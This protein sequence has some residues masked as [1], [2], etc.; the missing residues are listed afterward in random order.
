[1]KIGFIG[2]GIMGKP[3]SKNL[4]KAGHELV[5]CDFNKD[6]V[7]EVVA[8]GAKEGANGAEIAKECDVIITMLP[9]SPHVRS[10]ALG[11][12][13]IVE[14]AHEGTVLIDMSSID[15]VESKKIGAELAKKGIEMLDAPVSGGEPKAIDGT[16][17]VMVGGKKELF[18]KYYDMLMVM[19]GSVVY[20]GELGSGNVAKLANQIVVAVNIAAVGEALSFAK[21]AGTDPELV[22]QAIRGGLAGSTVMDAKAP[23]MLSRNFKPGFRIELH[24]KDLTN[25][26]NAAHAIAAPVPLTGQ[27]ME[28]MQ[29]LKADGYEKEDHSSLVKYYEKISNVT[30]E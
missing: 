10:V 17:S 6:A 11:E 26:L 30:V 29:A 8:A 23:M 16:L 9:N 22:Y 27:L 4:L 21:K 1:M 24:I 18:D 28:M 20:V 7:A 14:G 13:G 3:M 2:L 5:V 19:A 25:A 15:P 12:N